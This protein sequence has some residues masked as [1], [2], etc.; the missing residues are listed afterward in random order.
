[1]QLSWTGCLTYQG[2]LLLLSRSDMS[3]CNPTDCVLPGFSVHHQLL[4]LT[5]VWV[6]FHLF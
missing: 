1:M 3:D 6:Y 2:L 4:E 5:S